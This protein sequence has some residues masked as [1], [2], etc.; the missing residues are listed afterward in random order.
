[1]VLGCPETNQGAI[2][3]SHA[4]QRRTKTWTHLAPPV[5]TTSPAAAAD[6]AKTGTEE[7][8]AEEEGEEVARGEEAEAEVQLETVDGE[9]VVAVVGRGG[10]AGAEGVDTLVVGRGGAGGK[11]DGG[12]RVRRARGL[13][14]GGVGVAMPAKGRSRARRLRLKRCNPQQAAV[15]YL[16]VPCSSVAIYA[17]WEGLAGCC[18]KRSEVG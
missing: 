8:E 10:A 16:A 14:V 17:P 18:S 5:C 7:E 11:T 9:V 2:R 3:G 12:G 13:G 6:E 4:R 1:M 15:S